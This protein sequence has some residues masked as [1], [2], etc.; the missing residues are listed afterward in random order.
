MK[1]EAMFRLRAALDDILRDRKLLVKILS[2]ILIL[3]IAIIFRMHESAKADIT[4]ENETYD[5]EP[6]P[7]ELCV[8]IGGAVKNPGVY[9]VTESTRVYEVIEMA[10]GLTDK[11]DTDSINRAAFVQDGEKII[12]PFRYDPEEG[13]STGMSA[14]PGYTTHSGLVNIN[15]GSKEELM[16]L[17]GIGE[18][19]AGRI[20][21]Y[22][23]QNRFRKIED[24]KSVKGIGDGIFEKIKDS[25]TV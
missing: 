8:D 3:M 2:V 17:N 10:G 1:T 23:T 25:I 5:Q 14:A 20:I 16:T 15:T 24:I 11:A 9:T 12:V 4:I 7:V 22:R 19:M 21:E 6:A 18:V 13:D